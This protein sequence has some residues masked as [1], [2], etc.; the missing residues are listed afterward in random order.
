MN[1]NPRLERMTMSELLD[2]HQRQIVDL[3]ER[4]SAV[5]RAPAGERPSGGGLDLVPLVVKLAGAVARAAADAGGQ[6]DAGERRASGRSLADALHAAQAA[7][8]DA[9]KPG[10]LAE[11]LAAHRAE[12][13]PAPAEF[14]GGRHAAEPEHVHVALPPKVAAT[15]PQQHENA[16]QRTESNP[17]AV[18]VWNRPCTEHVDAQASQLTAG[19]DVRRLRVRHSDRAAVQEFLRDHDGDLLV[20]WRRKTYRLRSASAPRGHLDLEIE[21]EPQGLRHIEFPKPPRVDEVLGRET[22]EDRK[23]LRRDFAAS[24][25]GHVT[26]CTECGGAPGEVHPAWCSYAAVIRKP[27]AKT[28]SPYTDLGQVLTKG[29]RFAVEW[30][31]GTSRT[32]TYSGDPANPVAEPDPHKAMER[33]IRALYNIRD[34]I[35]APAPE[36]YTMPDGVGLGTVP[37]YGQP[38]GTVTSGLI[39]ATPETLCSAE[40]DGFVCCMTADHTGDHVATGPDIVYAT[41]PADPDVDEVLP[42]PP[43]TAYGDLYARL[44]AIH[45]ATA[46]EDQ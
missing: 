25:P 6:R 12:P 18:S 36:A 20:R 23:Q 11:W 31:D 24:R 4:V 35:A 7:A 34:D 32:Y 40:H 33:N 8:D 2:L 42:M 29:E 16:E 43:R 38:A 28:V 37:E 45:D 3:Q 9:P 10:W 19:T 21:P 13:V 1:P 5:E 17:N 41:W 46:E 44:D 27:G 39:H 14:A 30:P 15:I 22:Q 26:A